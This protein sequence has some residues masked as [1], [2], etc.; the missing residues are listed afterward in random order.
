MLEMRWD[1]FSGLGDIPPFGGLQ[2]IVVGD[3]YQ[4]P[5]V[6][7][8]FDV[9]MENENLQEVGYD[10]KIGRQGSYAFE[11][12]AW[13]QSSFHILELIEV[14]RQ[15]ENNNLSELLNSIREGEPDL[16]TKH[17]KTLNALQSPFPK[18]MLLSS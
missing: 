15:V 8:G 16:V 4:L 14:H 18:G 10:L 11:S 17:Q 12:H 6:P 1:T 2:L 7:A 5:P 9:L 3:F 13:H